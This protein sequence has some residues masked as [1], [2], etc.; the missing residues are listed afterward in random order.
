MKNGLRSAIA[1][2][3]FLFFS[4]NF[5]AGQTSSAFKVKAT[6]TGQTT[7]HIA[8]LSIQNNGELPIKT[9]PE[10]LF[11]PSGGQY[12]PYVCEIPGIT[13]PPGETLIIPVDGYCADVFTPPVPSGTTMPPLEDWIPVGSGT[14]LGDLV[15]I[16]P[17]DPQL[18][19]TPADIPMITVSPGYTPR[20]TISPGMNPTWPG[21]DKPIGGIIHPGKDPETIAPVLIEAIHNIAKAYDKLSDDGKIT[22]PFSGD[23]EKE[24]EAVIQQTFWIYTSSLSGKKYEKETF[25]EKVIKQ[26]ETN[27]GTAIATL[28]EKDKENLNSGV[29]EFWKTFTAVGTE[30]KVLS[31]V[32]VPAVENQPIFATEGINEADAK[33]CGS[34]K[35]KVTT[36]P[37]KYFNSVGEIVVYVT[38]DCDFC[39]PKPDYVPVVIKEGE[40]GIQP[41]FV[42]V[43]KDSSITL[44][45]DQEKEIVMDVHFQPSPVDDTRALYPPV[46][47][48][49]E[50][51]VVTPKKSPSGSYSD[52]YLLQSNI[53]KRHD[54]KVLVTPNRCYSIADKD[55][56]YGIGELPPG[57]Y[58]LKVY[59]RHKRTNFPEADVVVEEGKVTIRDFVLDREVKKKEEVKKDE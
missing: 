28:P 15:S 58:H 17:H 45:N 31:E 7:G 8:N 16:I 29:D 27:T 22:T 50:S 12:Q 35:G 9:K 1:I 49:G 24:R 51:T 20:P 52:D 33:A 21:T 46:L 41:S 3:A 26:F 39:P 18:P 40:N 38:S 44:M 48:K 53:D 34:I 14:P 42:I 55:G 10:S 30:A 4:P 54:A 32:K 56:N 5:I 36:D 13:V 59:T 23:P 43:P 57:S 2:V 25:G 6:G 11:I 19:F 47:K 37:E